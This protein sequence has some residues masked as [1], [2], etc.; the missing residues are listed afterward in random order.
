MFRYM[1][2]VACGCGDQLK[3]QG[4]GRKTVLQNLKSSFAEHRDM[5]SRGM[6]P[7]ESI[8]APAKTGKGEDAG[9]LARLGSDLR[10]ARL[11]LGW[12]LPDIAAGLR[13]RLTYLEALERGHADGLPGVAY[14]IGFLR[15]YGA[16]LG[17]DPDELSRRYRSEAAVEP[18]RTTLTFPAPVPE[19]GVPAGAVV[20]LGVVL[21]VG[22]YVG[23]YRLSG[24][25]RLPPEVTPPVPARLAPLAEQAVPP[26]TP[27]AAVPLRADGAPA[28]GAAGAGAPARPSVLAMALP[29]GAATGS[30][31]T[32]IPP[33][34]AAPVVPPPG[35]TASAVPAAYNPGGPDPGVAATADPNQP[36]IVIRARADAWV[37]VRESGGHVLLSRMLRAGESWAVPP[38]KTGLLMTLGNAGG[39]DIVVDGTVA[40]G[41]GQSGVV[42][43]DVPLDADVLKAGHAPGQQSTQVA[44]QS[45]G[46]Q[47]SAAHAA[48][49]SGI[50]PA[51]PRGD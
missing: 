10:N 40:P 34:L 41:F 13:I 12:E 6:I 39:T 14:A 48:P 9:G 27:A 1:P 50:H 3:Q 32:P 8:E 2:Q 26:P 46:F 31:P 7:P 16:A 4:S 24:D 20:L 23:W 5:M 37:Q 29:P 51:T 15:T 11:R 38:G 45:G 33:I 47:P 19:R 35:Q 43:R 22:A 21:A 28:G 44:G 30:V 36:R 17:L 18:S 49:L 25:G 42:R